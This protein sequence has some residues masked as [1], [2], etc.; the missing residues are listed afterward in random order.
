MVFLVSDSQPT[1]L[2]PSA[3]FPGNCRTQLAHW[4]IPQCSF[5]VGQGTFCRISHKRF[6]VPI[7]RVLFSGG[8]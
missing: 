7:A 5:P 3:M 1:V 8:L 2:F 4:V 6:S